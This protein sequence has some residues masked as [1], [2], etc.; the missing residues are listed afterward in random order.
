MTWI[1]IKR[2][3]IQE[4]DLVTL[5]RGWEGRGGEQTCNCIQAPIKNEK[6]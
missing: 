1:K 4:K 6:Q 5:R 2:S 3:N